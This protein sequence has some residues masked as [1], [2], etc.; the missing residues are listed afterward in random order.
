MSLCGH[1]LGQYPGTPS[2]GPAC[3]VWLMVGYPLM[4]P[5]GHQSIGLW[6][7]GYGG[8]AGWGGMKWLITL[9]CFYLFLFY[10]TNKCY[11]S[12][13][14]A[15][16]ITVCESKYGIN[17]PSRVSVSQIYVSYSCNYDDK[18]ILTWLYKHKQGIR[19]FQTQNWRITHATTSSV[20]H[21]AL[22]PFVRDV[23]TKKSKP[24]WVPFG[25]LY[26]RE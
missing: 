20:W 8:A 12:R 16:C 9:H 25:W 14:V 21:H 2:H 24:T 7:L 15:P 1:C 13:E 18:M 26:L 22:L 10:F 3:A 6:R 17:K 5:A 23:L 11:P 4:R 19:N